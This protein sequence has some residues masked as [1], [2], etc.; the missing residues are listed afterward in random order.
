MNT[1]IE[2]VRKLIVNKTGRVGLVLQK[3][4]PEIML[5][6]GVVGGIAATVM[7][8]KATLKAEEVL[9]SCK[10]ELD[11]INEVQNN[12]EKYKEH[13]YTD[14]K[15]KKDLVISYVHSGMKWVKLYGP[16]VSLGT[17]S[18]I[19]VLASHGVMKKRSVALV[20]AY[21]L[22]SESFNAYRKR[23]REKLGEEQEYEFRH[24]TATESVNV[25]D[26]ET[27]KKK[28]VKVQ[29][30]RH[31]ELLS[32]YSRFFDEYS[33]QWQKDNQY[34]MM[35]LRTQQNYANNL[36]Q[37]RGYV[38]LN[39]VYDMLGLKQTPAGQ[40]V[41]WV[42]GKGDPFVD[43]GITRES[44]ADF[45]NGHEKSILLDFNVAGVIYDAIG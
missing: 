40:L 45:I 1:Q 35:F 14:E 37:A 26:P 32:E 13:Q 33:V 8:C 11:K 30:K 2:L 38:F 43:F 10:D 17:A 6:A 12:K 15:Y 20:G 4:A 22:V 36:L 18:L 31:P 27:G 28:K 25:D 23:V 24:D 16:S 41:G 29:T 9:K 39:E 19:C 7:A 3:Y 5:T 34:N 44:G 21:N 42:E